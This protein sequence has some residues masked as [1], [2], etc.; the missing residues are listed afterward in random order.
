MTAVKEVEPEEEEKED[1]DSLASLEDDEG[2][3]RK[4]AETSL[5]SSKAPSEAVTMEAAA[6]TRSR[7]GVGIVA[8]IMDREAEECVNGPP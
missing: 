3:G 4:L 1:E 7:G 6:T 8:E 2:D 5:S